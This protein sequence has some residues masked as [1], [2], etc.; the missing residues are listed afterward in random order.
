[1]DY[2]QTL[3][4]SKG[5]SQDEIK[6]AYR[7]LA[8]Q[9]HPDKKS[10]DEKEFKKVNEAYQVL[11]DPKKRAQYDQF[12]SAGFGQGFGGAGGG[13]GFDGFDFSQG[14]FGDFFRSQQGG[15]FGGAQGGRADFNVEDVFDIFGDAFG[16]R[17]GRQ[18]RHAQG[19][20][21]HAGMSVSF[22]D[23]ARGA[24]KKVELTKDSPCKECEGT[25]VKEGSEMIECATCNGKG[26]VRETMGAIFGNFT[27][28]ST[29][30]V[31]RGKGKIPKE[32]CRACKGEGKTRNRQVIEI[33]IPAGIKNGESIMIRGMGQA[34]FRDEPAGDLYL[35]IDVESDPVFK[36]AG[37]DIVYDMPVKL[38]DAILGAKVSVPTLDEDTELKI[39][40]GT[41]DGEELRIKGA[42]VWGPGKG[43]QVVRVKIQIPKKLSGKAKKL[44]E[45]LAEELN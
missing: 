30:N 33:N 45:E 3:G 38:T 6:K 10:G 22:R 40:A 19:D 41:H 4:V 21:I 1:M 26:E 14:G 18:R 35:K 28:I 17:Q 43:D 15:P 12:G 25:G 34:G 5:A 31:C 44:V 7:K 37:N 13:Q 2:Y 9:H 42:G 32:N 23:A 29:C 36:R 8:H 39:P 24:V 11:S 27:R 16:F 20:D